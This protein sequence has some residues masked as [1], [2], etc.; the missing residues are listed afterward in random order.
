MKKVSIQEAFKAWN[1]EQIRPKLPEGHE[2]RFLERLTTQKQFHKRRA[3]L[4]WAAVAL[5][6]IGLS[7]TFWFTPA[8]PTEEVL[9]FQKAET[10]F[11]FLID[12]QLEKLSHFDSPQGTQ[13]M[14][15][16]K[17]QINRIQGDYQMLYQQWEQE[18]NQSKLIQALISNLKTQIELLN[19]L[20]NQLITIK[21]LENEDKI[22]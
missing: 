20:Q 22:L 18:P 14:E 16:S 13:F 10:H 19:E 9:K 21:N 6:C 5:L 4:R 1:A 3:V 2:Q 11:N 7:Q 12:Q 17:R 15:D 8:K